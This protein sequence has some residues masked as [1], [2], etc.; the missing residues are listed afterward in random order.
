[1]RAFC[2]V[3]HLCLLR[4]VA[5]VVAVLIILPILQSHG[6]IVQQH[7]QMVTRVTGV[8]V[9]LDVVTECCL[10]TSRYIEARARVG[11]TKQSN[12]FHLVHHLSVL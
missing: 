3:H 2:F 5:G 9:A 7:K 8:V 10:R 11:L 6:A 12:G 1:M 4:C